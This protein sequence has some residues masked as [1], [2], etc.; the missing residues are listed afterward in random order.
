M[1]A[2]LTNETPRVIRS[3]PH[4]S[5]VRELLT[6][7]QEVLDAVDDL[8]RVPMVL[9]KHRGWLHYLPRPKWLVRYFV[10]RHVGRSLAG[11]SRRLSARAALGQALDGEGQ[12]REAVKE[13]QQSLPPVRQKVY[14]VLLIAAIVV[15][16]RP[17]IWLGVRLLGFSAS[18]RQALSQQL[19]EAVHAAESAVTASVASLDQ[20]LNAVVTGGPLLL[21]VGTLCVAVAAYM[22]LLPFIPAFRLKRMLFNLAPDPDWR[23][24]SAVA[25][26]SVSQA[27]GLYE[28]ERLVSAEL[29]ARPPKEFPLDLTASALAIALPLEICINLFRLMGEDIYVLAKYPG[30]R[31][32]TY[33]LGEACSIFLV[34]AC[35]LI[36]I[37]I[38]VGWLCRTWR[39]RQSDRPVSYIPFE[40]GIHG[41]RAVAR[42]ENPIGWR[43]L[44]FVVFFV[45]WAG[46]VISPTGLDS[47]FRVSDALLWAFIVALAA[48]LLISLPWWYRI[49]R[50][51][52][53]LD[54]SYDSHKAGIRPLRSLLMMTVG[55]L[56]L[57]PP[58]IAV[59]RVGRHIQ[60]AQARAAQP[61][62]VWSP[63]I[64]AP[65]LLLSPVLFAYLQRELNK[66]WTVEGEPLDS[67][68]ADSSTGS[69]GEVGTLPWLKAER[70]NHRAGERVP[71]RRRP[72]LPL[73]SH[74]SRPDEP[75]WPTSAGS[76]MS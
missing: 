60:R 13:F 28:R 11:L 40:V 71:T 23:H 7:Y 1:V 37:L 51:L 31:Y 34:A 47:T 56:V 62:T 39:R 44:F 75:V 27:T 15:I 5:Q 20:A 43:L 49:N 46:M 19:L 70:P 64:L 21:G 76:G 32:S 24:R 16:C 38:R 45:F 61:V 58:F 30:F 8:P 29:G 18:S 2:G 74:D 42:V 63:W 65:G 25:R 3:T 10:V 57:A 41:E 52:R 26:W 68:P 69:N 17:I 67:W 6:V 36:L 53:D 50:Q 12:E 66:I 22:A 59:F 48:S 72:I 54:R 35:V 9:R 73:T 55:W 14:V 4:G 33:F